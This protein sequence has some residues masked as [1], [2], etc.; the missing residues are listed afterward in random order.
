MAQLNTNNDKEV[1]KHELDS[2]AHSWMTTTAS[3]SSRAANTR[4]SR[5]P[6]MADLVL[7]AV[8][9]GECD[10]PVSCG[11]AQVECRDEHGNPLTVETM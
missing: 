2:S 3:S 11:G 10:G 4:K 5:L 1:A 6:G 8:E 7:L 9:L